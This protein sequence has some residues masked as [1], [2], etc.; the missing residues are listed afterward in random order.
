MYEEFF[1]LRWYPCGLM[2]IEE[3][4]GQCEVKLET[5]KPGDRESV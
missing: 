1:I 4:W 5:L 3:K 2:G